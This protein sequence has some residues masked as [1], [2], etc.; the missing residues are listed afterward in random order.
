MLAPLGCPPTEVD[1]SEPYDPSMPPPSV[2]P[3]PPPPYGAPPAPPPY[4]A[5]PAAPPYGAPPAPPAYGAPPPAY[6]APPAAPTY[7][8]DYGPPPGQRVNDPAPMGMRLL[9]RIID[10]ILTGVVSGIIA[11]AIG[12]HLFSTTTTADG[13]SQASFRLYDGDYFKYVLIMLIVTG[14]YEVS[15]LVSRGATL[16]KMAV[17]VRVAMLADG[18][19]PDF[20][21][22]ATRWAIPAVAGA[23]FGLLEIIV[24]L[25]PFFD[26]TKRN[27]GWYDNAAKTIAVRTK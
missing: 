23:I 15:M 18:Q 21:A 12:I 4:G 3:P 10:G 9:A 27:R 17:G 19:N 11:L 8:S 20:S 13:T 26:S 1:M 6:G 7:G 22:A 5:P 14:I 24:F 25:S 2:P 16:G